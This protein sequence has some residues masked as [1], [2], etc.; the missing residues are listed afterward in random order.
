MIHLTISIVYVSI[1]IYNSIFRIKL[2]IQYIRLNHQIN[3]CATIKQRGNV[4]DEQLKSE[5]NSIKSQQFITL[6][7]EKKT[8]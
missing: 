6:C 3:L 4:R 8:R 5:R 1:S 7:A 2:K